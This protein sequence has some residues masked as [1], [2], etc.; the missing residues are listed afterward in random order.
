MKSISVRIME[1]YWI[2]KLMSEHQFKKI[3]RDGNLCAITLTDSYEIHFID[4]SFTIG[5]VRHEVRHAYIN[6]LCLDSIK[7]TV[8]QMEE[9]NCTLDQYY[10]NEMGKTSTEIFRLLGQGK[11][12]F[13]KS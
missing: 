4:T 5:V 10:W 13:M 9:L 1:K 11:I 7:L 12:R 8:H 2:C 6:S 3:H